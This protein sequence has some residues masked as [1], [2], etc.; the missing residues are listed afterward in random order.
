MKQIMVAFLLLITLYGTAQKSKEPNLDSMMKLMNSKE[1]IPPGFNSSTTILII[2]KDSRKAVNKYLEKDIEKE[3]TGEYRLIE[4]GDR[5]NPKDTAK[6]RYFMKIVP[7]FIPGR[8]TESGRETP[9]TEY[10]IMMMDRLTIYGDNLL[11]KWQS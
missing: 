9:D 1:E 2:Y 8:F 3:Y 4:E 5:L 11:L 10:Q 6:A 7:K